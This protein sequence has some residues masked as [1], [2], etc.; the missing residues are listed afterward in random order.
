MAGD[1]EDV[2]VTA[3]AHVHDQEIVLWHRRRQLL[4]EGQRVRWLQRRDDAFEPGAELEGRERLLVGDGHIFH[5]SA[6]LEPGV[7][8]PDAW[9]VEAGRDRMALEDL[10]VLGLQQV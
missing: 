5:A 6:L 4:D 8:R 7:L 2:L 9:I 1:G 10:S 3:A